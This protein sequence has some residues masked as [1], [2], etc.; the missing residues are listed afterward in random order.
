MGTL[1]FSLIKLEILA[2]KIETRRITKMREI[3]VALYHMKIES[4]GRTNGLLGG[5]ADMA[6]LSGFLIYFTYPPT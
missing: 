2:S 5:R 6:K 1:Y 4:D 3:V